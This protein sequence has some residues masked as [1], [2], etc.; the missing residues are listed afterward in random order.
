M[1]QQRSSILDSLGIPALAGI[2]AAFGGL[3]AMVVLFVLWLLSDGTGDRPAEVAQDDAPASAEVVVSTSE[4]ADPFVAR[5]TSAQE[6]ED[7]TSQTSGD[8][9]GAAAPTNDPAQ[10]QEALAKLRKIQIA[11]ANYESAYKRLGHSASDP[12][13]DGHN[14][15]LSWRV[16]LLPFL[17]QRPLFDQFHLDEPWDSPHN[18]QVAKQ[19]PEVYRLSQSETGTTRFQVIQGEDMIFGSSKR[20][21]FGDVSDG[22]SNTILALVVGS[23]KAVPWTQPEDFKFDKTAPVESLG[24]YQ[25]GMIPIALGFDAPVLIGTTVD[26]S[27]LLAMATARAGEAIVAGNITEETIGSSMEDLSAGMQQ[28]VQE[29][30]PSLDATQSE[31]ATKLEKIKFGL[32]NLEASKRTYAPVKTSRVPESNRRRVFHSELS[33]RVHILP[34][35]GHEP[36]YEKFRLQEPWNSPHNA[37]LAANMPDVFRLGNASG[38]VSRFSL[39]EGENLLFGSSSSPRRGDIRDGAGNT[40]LCVIVGQDK[41]TP[42][43]RP[44]DFAFD[45]TNPITSLGQLGK[46]GIYCSTVDGKDLLLPLSTTDSEFLAAVTHDGNEVQH[47]LRHGKSLKGF[48]KSAEP[49]TRNTNSNF[50]FKDSPALEQERKQLKLAVSALSMH[51]KLFHRFSLEL[52]TD[53]AADERP[54]T[55]L[56]W[57]VHLLPLLGLESLYKQ[58]DFNA[59]W[60]EG[61]NA[62]LL[63]KIPAIYS[64]GNGN[65]TRLRAFEGFV[66][67]SYKEIRD[68]LPNTAA[69]ILVGNDLATEWTRPD[70]LQKDIS[71][72]LS[73]LKNKPIQLATLDGELLSLSPQ[74]AEQHLASLASINGGEI[75]DASALRSQG[76]AIAAELN[77]AFSKKMQKEMETH[78][79]W[80]QK[81]QQ[82][83]S[84]WVN[85]ESAYRKFPG[86]TLSRPEQMDSTGRPLLSWRVHIL[87]FIGESTLHQKFH[88]DEPWDSKHNRP[89]LKKMPALFRAPGALPNVYKTR[90]QTFEGSKTF[91]EPGKSF[92]FSAVRDGTRS[93]IALVATGEDKSV[94]WTKPEDITFVPTDVLGSLGEIGTTIHCARIDGATH[95]LKST[96]PNDILSGLITPASGERLP[97]WFRGSGY[98]FR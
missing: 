13:P 15:K 57:R 7:T 95:V 48:K 30:L 89:L 49:L 24:T 31:I 73:S 47:A 16:L 9:A 76:G 75:V 14:P 1:N 4:F 6:S 67:S 68:G 65:R 51:E 54:G 44:S 35:I 77:P 92:G 8:P 79:L 63:D 32:L 50:A 17:D 33:W 88:L 90:V 23:N 42:W 2:G 85:F 97:K 74:Q 46:D 59:K 93:T 26:D 56:S 36:L 20:A 58:F 38:S 69:C 52:P 86:M 10:I 18:Q 80:S 55:Q 94:F 39:I 29:S 45:Q 53:A 83:V 91:L 71:A 62:A 3:L 87:P 84:G 22:M 19:M 37:A 40:I 12:H 27:K 60:N 61:Q 34:F 70:P 43:T 78:D 11:I 96:T 98:G 25:D 41:A 66:G 28:Q 64:T 5:S 21:R 82:I 72:I 81:L